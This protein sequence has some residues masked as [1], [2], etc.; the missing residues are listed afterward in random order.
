MPV[1]G[2]VV[3]ERPLPGGVFDMGRR[4]RLARG[5]RGLPREL[6]R[7]QGGARV[8]A[9]AARDLRGNVLGNIGAE[10]DGAAL[11]DTQQI[12]HLE[13]LAARSRCIARAARR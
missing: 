4:E 3:A 11:D 10:L 5:A 8:A 12:L 13:R 9:R 1:T 2:P 7:L 6:E